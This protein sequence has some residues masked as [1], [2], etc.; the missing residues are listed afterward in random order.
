MMNL[1][2][3]EICSQT[4][5]KLL[6]AEQMFQMFLYGK[7]EKESWGFSCLDFSWWHGYCSGRRIISTSDTKL[8]VSDEFFILF[9]KSERI[10]GCWSMNFFFFG[11]F[12]SSTVTKTD[13][14]PAAK[15]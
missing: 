13:P 2:G 5:N 9:L 4:F 6:K 3:K 11:V 8:L 10:C 14:G 7:N 12:E 1:K 15:N